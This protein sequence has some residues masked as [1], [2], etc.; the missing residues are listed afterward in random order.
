MDRQQ[1]LHLVAESGLLASGNAFDDQ[2]RKRAL[3]DTFS[4]LWAELRGN[5]PPPTPDMIL[6]ACAGVKTAGQLLQA[7]QYMGRLH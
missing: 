7:V 2:T 1:F 5:T 3:V 4:M 6:S